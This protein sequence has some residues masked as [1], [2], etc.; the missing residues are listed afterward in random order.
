MSHGVELSNTLC[1][2]RFNKLKKFGKYCFAKVLLL[3]KFFSDFERVV[4]NDRNQLN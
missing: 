3:K 2:F 1:L 4:K